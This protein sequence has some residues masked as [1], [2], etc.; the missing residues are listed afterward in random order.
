[1]AYRVSLAVPA[2]TG[3]YA[4]FER[5]REAAPIHAEKWFTGLFKAIFS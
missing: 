3:T 4:V 2:E 1:M 5:I